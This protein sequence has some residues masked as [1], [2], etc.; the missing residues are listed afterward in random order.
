MSSHRALEEQGQTRAQN[1]D[2]ARVGPP[3]TVFQRREATSHVALHGPGKRAGEPALLRARRGRLRTCGT[4]ARAA[5]RRGAPAAIHRRE[6]LGRRHVWLARSTTHRAPCRRSSRLDV[7]AYG[8]VRVAVCDDAFSDAGTLVAARRVC[9]DATPRAH[10][11]VTHSYAALSFQLRG[12]ARVEQD[13]QWTVREGDVH[14]VPAGAAHRAL[15]A[16]ATEAW[17]VG[18]SAPCMV[19]EGVAALLEPFERVRDGGSAVLTIAA[20]RRAYLRH[21]FKELEAT[22]RVPGS[23]EM[24]AA[25]RRS[26]LTLILA[27]VQR[28]TP[29]VTPAPG[30]GVVVDALRH[31]ERHCLGPLTLREVADAVGRTPAYV[32]GA[33][34][35][36]TG[37][38][39]V[40]WIISGRMVEARRLLLHSDER[41][42]VVAER[43]GYADPTHF[44]RLFRREHGQTPAAWRAARRLNRAPSPSRR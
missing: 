14:L 33:L 41:V 19:A 11:P 3:P 20:E 2:C 5:L 35:R 10:P 25:V 28:A 29:S 36:A 21:L 26:L 17:C 23:G 12:E 32:T 4:P 16:G 31:I 13:G 39:A 37:R 44:I 1:T 24:A 42:D 15:G 18:L 27:E 7:A 40:Q 43:V 6:V 8:I 30:G 34:T 9:G 38:S 22:T